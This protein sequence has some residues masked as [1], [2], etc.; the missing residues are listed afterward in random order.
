M[1]FIEAY[2]IT[3]HFLFLS[4]LISISACSG[5]SPY[6]QSIPPCPSTNAS[7]QCFSHP[8]DAPAGM[9]RLY[10]FRPDLDDSYGGDEPVLI[11][12]SSLEITLEQ[13][14]YAPLDLILGKHH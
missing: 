14:S 7:D 11:I 13:W 10:V 4:V 6:N 1:I 9:A 5:I 2:R 12:D 3:S 8:G